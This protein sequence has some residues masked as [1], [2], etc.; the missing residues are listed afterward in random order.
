M[1]ISN[2]KWVLKFYSINNLKSF[3][4]QVLFEFNKHNILKLKE[5]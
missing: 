3:T 2:F 4:K 1:Q 5:Y